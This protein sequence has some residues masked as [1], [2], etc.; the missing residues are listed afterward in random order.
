MSPFEMLAEAL[1]RDWAVLQE[2]AGDR[3]ASYEPQILQLL[4]ALEGEPDAAI[5][6]RDRLLQLLDGIEG[7][8]EQLER[9]LA[10]L[11]PAQPVPTVRSRGMQSA[12]SVG[13]GRRQVRH[14]VVPV[15]FATD[16]AET[17]PEAGYFSG[18]RGKLVYGVA[19]VSVPDDHRMGAL[20]RPR[21][22]RLEFRPNPDKHV[23]VLSVDPLD[24][25]R[26]IERVREP[27][28]GGAPKEALIFVHGYNVAFVDALRRTA[29]LAKD[30]DF[31]GPAISYSWP[32]E[33]STL[34][35]TV[36]EA[37]VR[38]TQPHFLEFLELCTRE[39]GLQDVHVIA[40]SMG[41]RL[42]AE[43]L[44][45]SRGVGLGEGEARLH[46]V[47]F[48]A[49]DIDSETFLDL[50]EQ[51]RR[52]Q[53]KCTL[54]SSS[55]DLALKASKLVHKHPRAGDSGTNLVVV[56]G[57][58]TVDASAVDTSLLGHSY[59]GDTRTLIGDLFALLIDGKRPEERFGLEQ[60]GPDGAR[61]WR[62]KP[63]Q[64]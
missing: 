62:F 17:T 37:N 42:L 32:S 64:Q 56:P 23:V 7:A 52:E 8:R 58:D 27:V 31:P 36:D 19:G 51:F 13:M 9:T 1:A 11:Q 21:W 45:N 26:F 22:W 12:P 29:Q 54:Y 60:A 39:M 18:G 14:A 50:A 16:R 33:A 20:E 59:F 2:L 48:A 63:A 4:R 43:T 41:G 10:A 34:Q 3:W 28:N 6:A 47:V 57:V 40:H 15:A 24:R 38:W 53:R 61:H 55:N 5:E 35:Y 44:G 25:A 30:L 46:Q 49:P